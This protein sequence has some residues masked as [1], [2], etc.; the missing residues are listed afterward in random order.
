MCQFCVQHG[1]GK[2][3]YLEASTYAYDLD[4]DLKRREY[5]LDFVKDFGANRAW[6]L[7][8]LERLERLPARFQ[9]LG[10]AAA[11]R[12]MMPSHFGQP[13]PIEE[14]E[15]IL[16]ICTS[17]VRIP[18]PCRYEAGTPDEG[19]CLAITT[20]PIDAALEEAYADYDIGPDTAKF[21]R[22]TKAETMELL[23]R[24]EQEGL[25]H[26]VWTFVTPFVA[27]I[28]NCS[29][30]A[31]CMAMRLTVEH[32]TPNM[33][34]GHSIAHADMEACVGC[35]DCVERC[36]FNALTIGPGHKRAIVDGERCYGC[37]VCRSACEHDALTLVP[38][39]T[40]PPASATGIPVT[41]AR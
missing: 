21:Q 16:D 39:E 1:D 26:S 9:R 37:G 8:N 41:A 3:W 25:M 30:E 28:C 35:A 40:A 19:Y 31:G 11:S 33:F 23:R 29:L 27:A 17:V 20:K 38:R 36:P 14:C 24:T 4:A 10:K 7:E 18:C 34:K 12:S 6:A 2:T 13:V 5:L 22:L 15:A 32:D